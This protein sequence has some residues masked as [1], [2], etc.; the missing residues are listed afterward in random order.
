MKSA[1]PLLAALL[2]VA[3]CREPADGERMGDRAY[4]RGDFAAAH[5][6]YAA[7]AAGGAGAQVLAKLGIAALRRG[8]APG[9][10]DAYRRLG[11]EEPSHATEAAEGLVAA[12]RIALTQRNAAALDAAV[13]AL[14]SVAPERPVGQW[15]IELARGGMLNDPELIALAPE[16]LAA[17]RDAGSGDSL[18]VAWADALVRATDCEG[19]GSLYRAVARRTA[20]NA[21]AA[22]ARAG[23]SA[24][25]LA[26]AAKALAARDTAA[27][28]DALGSV[29]QWADADAEAAEAAALATELRA[30]AARVPPMDTTFM[31]MDTSFLP[32]DTTAPPTDTTSFRD[33]R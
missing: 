28:L 24:C 25:A 2:L 16:G 6:A 20:D 14:R 12:A 9:A 23:A 11:T 19:A 32:T 8:D 1:A 33:D 18:V 5:E 29:Q 7:A 21:L 3:A 10:V 30:A 17:A 15:V 13:A 22:S 27:A 4:A 26:A 31:P